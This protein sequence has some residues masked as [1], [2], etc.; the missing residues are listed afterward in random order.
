MVLSLVNPADVLM[1]LLAE[2]PTIP[3]ITSLAFVVV[4][5]VPEVDV[6]WPWFVIALATPGSKGVTV[7]TP[8]T[9]ITTTIVPPLAALLPNVIT[10]FA[11]AL[12]GIA[13]QHCI[14]PELAWAFE[15][16]AWREVQVESAVSEIV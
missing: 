10:S 4:M 1:T 9:D 6:A 8:V 7:L 13:Y 12:A 3:I 11:S 15:S 14:S 16:A 2:V 5:P